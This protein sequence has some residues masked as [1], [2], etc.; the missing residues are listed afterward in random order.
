MP[1]EPIVREP[2][3][4]PSPNSS[5]RTWLGLAVGVPLGILATLLLQQMFVGPVRQGEV[6]GPLTVQGPIGPFASGP[7]DPAADTDPSSAPTGPAGAPGASAPGTD[8]SPMPA[9]AAP[10]PQPGVLGGS[11]PSGTISGNPNL[12]VQPIVIGDPQA[13]PPEPKV[14]MRDVAI[15][16]GAADFE[17]LGE[18]LASLA[19]SSGGRSEKF[20]VPGSADSAEVEGIVL[21]VPEKSLRNVLQKVQASGPSTVL[22][23]WSGAGADRESRLERPLRLRLAELEKERQKLLLKYLDDAPL[24]LRVTEKIELAK[25]QLR[26]VRA[27]PASSAVVR[28]YFG[29][30][31]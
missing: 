14:Q 20:I 26:A 23:E 5:A 8:P 9:P 21:E 16:V 10:T 24:V 1:N 27:V 17:S 13:E 2:E 3:F 7:D 12:P 11:M 30:G 19:Q 4:E 28:V 31:I 25:R 6:R 15:A 18:R 22:D 29:A